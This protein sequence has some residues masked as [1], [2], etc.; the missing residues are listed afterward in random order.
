VLAGC[1]SQKEQHRRRR[2]RRRRFFRRRRS[3]HS[4][5]ERSATAAPDADHSAAWQ[6]DAGCS[7]RDRRRADFA[8]E[9]TL[10]GK[11][12]AGSSNALTS[13]AST[14]IWFAGLTDVELHR[15]VRPR[16]QGRP[17]HRRQI[18][19]RFDDRRSNCPAARVAEL[20]LRQLDRRRGWRR[21][22]AAAAP[23]PPARIVAPANVKA[24]ASPPAWA[25]PIIAAALKLH[26]CR[27]TRTACCAGRPAAT[28]PNPVIDALTS[29]SVVPA[30]H[31]SMLMP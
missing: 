12:I 7:T 17:R 2:C 26:G 16:R 31:G 3:P 21:S 23:L 10:G 18:R 27:L 19:Q 1:N 9:T 6:E 22:V 13:P 20:Y 28:P 5:C 29:N 11:T 8:F 25:K 4:G 24:L 14:Y 15:S 30:R